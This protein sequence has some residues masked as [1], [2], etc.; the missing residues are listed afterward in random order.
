MDK[1]TSKDANV[2]I[3]CADAR[4]SILLDRQDVCDKLGINRIHAPI[5][6]TGSIKFFM[7]ENLMD[8]LFEQLHIL[9][10]AHPEKIVVINHTDCGYYKKLGQDEEEIY[11]SDLKAGVEKIKAKYPQLKV[12]GYLLDI[13]TGDVQG[14]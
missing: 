10:H 3:R 6:E 7:N 13:E 2:V 1:L 12:E 14:A 5:S 4:V 8:K 9:D 11:L